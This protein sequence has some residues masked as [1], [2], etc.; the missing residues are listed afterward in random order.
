MHDDDTFTARMPDGRRIRLRAKRDIEKLND[1]DPSERLAAMLKMFPNPRESARSGSYN[2][3][4]RIFMGKAD[5]EDEADHDASDDPIRAP[6]SDHHAS[7]VADLLVETGRYPHRAAA[8]DHL[9]HDNRGQA[10]LARMH[11]K[12]SAMQ[13]TVH[14]I[15]KDAGIAGVCAA[16]IAKGTTTITEQELVEAASKVASERHPELSPAQAF[17]KVFTASTE[18]ARVLQKAVKIAEG[19]IR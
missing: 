16:I 14:S 9:L 3:F 8:L 7:K 10:L 18:E 2:K 6:V 1:L 19:M 15:M 17:S 12:E 4:L 5:D 11:K 13:D